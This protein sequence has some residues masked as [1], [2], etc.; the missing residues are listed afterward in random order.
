VHERT[1]IRTGESVALEFEL[2]GLGS[3]FLALCIDL[4]IQLAVLVGAL[5]AFGYASDA[6][7][8]AAAGLHVPPAVGEA[9]PLALF[10]IF[11]FVVTIGYFIIFEVWWDGRTPG[12]RA[13]GL[14]VI[15]DGGF[16]VDWGASTI[17]NLVRIVEATLGG[18]ALSV[19][20][21]LLSKENKRLGD[22]AAGTL[23]VRDGAVAPPPG[24]GGL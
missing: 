8:R 19:V 20:S 13:L 12:K 14:R 6:L 11:A 17:R 4:V 3:R 5:F 22:L 1:A 23:V 10:V 15:R 24:P 9:V 16:P 2:A 18:Y 21:V 7:R